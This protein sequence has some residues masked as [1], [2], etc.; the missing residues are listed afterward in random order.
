MKRLLVILPLLLGLLLPGCAPGAG[1]AGE[2]TILYA[3]EMYSCEFY[4]FAEVY[5]AAHP[6]VTLNLVGLEHNH[7]HDAHSEDEDPLG[8]AL[9]ALASG[10]I[11]ADL[12]VFDDVYLHRFTAR[13][14]L[15]DLD[16]FPAL[17]KTA[18]NPAL[19]DGIARFCRADGAFH[20]VP[21]NLAYTGF[22]INT[23]LFE[24]L[25]LAVP[26]KSWTYDDYYDLALRSRQDLN[27]DGRPDTWLAYVEDNSAF[28]FINPVYGA[29]V[30]GGYALLYDTP[31]FMDYMKKAEELRELGVFYIPGAHPDADTAEEMERLMTEEMRGEDKLMYPIYFW[32]LHGYRAEDWEELLVLPLPKRVVDGS[33]LGGITLGLHAGA[34]QSALAANFIAEFLSEDY[35]RAHATEMQLYGDIGKYEKM[36]NFSPSVVEWLEYS[37]RDCYNFAMPVGLAGWMNT[38]LYPRLASGV[39]SLEECAAEIRRE[40]EARMNR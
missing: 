35:Q 16:E 24:R 37:A 19:L 30:S 4:T 1:D 40:A 17:K 21:L 36:K 27:G 28:R 22:V 29:A 14:L 34:G 20:M 18:D 32:D 3:S 11:S 13:S 12:V 23:A 7:E 26:D 33:R 25:G 31:E 10:A 38:E 8:E 9:E 39:L 6:N 5:Q 2:L 15:R